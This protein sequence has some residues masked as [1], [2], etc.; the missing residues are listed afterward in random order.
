LF[1]FAINSGDDQSSPGMLLSLLSLCLA[2]LMAMFRDDEFSMLVS[3][4]EL[5][6]LIRETGTALLDARLSSSDELSEDAK[7]RMVRAI[8]KVSMKTDCRWF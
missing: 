8:N 6:L 7:S 4:A 5:S 1:G 2:T 3:A